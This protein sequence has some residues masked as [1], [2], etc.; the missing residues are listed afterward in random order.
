[1]IAGFFEATWFLWWLLAFVAVGWWTWR[2]FANDR[3]RPYAAPVPWRNL[4]QQVLAERDEAKLG[5]RIQDAEGAILVELANQVFTRDSA[6]RRALQEAMNNLHNLRQTH[7][8]TYD[9]NRAA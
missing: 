6:E 8:D 9:R 5:I 3:I 1:M 7:P 2:L 4:Y